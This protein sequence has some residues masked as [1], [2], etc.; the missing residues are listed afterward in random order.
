MLLILRGTKLKSENYV[1]IYINHDKD[2][3]LVASS[4]IAQIEQLTH[5]V[6]QHLSTGSHLSSPLT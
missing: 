1:H 4:R 2:F 6:S 5:T 3:P